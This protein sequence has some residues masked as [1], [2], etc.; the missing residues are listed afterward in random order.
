MQKV[1]QRPRVRIAQSPFSILNS[2]MALAKSKSLERSARWLI[3]RS[4]R[5]CNPTPNA[6][7]CTAWVTVRYISP[8]TKCF[9]RKWMIGMSTD[10]VYFGDFKL[11]IKTSPL[12]ELDTMI[13]NKSHENT[14]G[15]VPVCKGKDNRL[16]P[17]IRIEKR[18]WKFNA[19]LYHPARL[20]TREMLIEFQTTSGMTKRF[21]L[22]AKNR[23]IQH[24]TGLRTLYEYTKPRSGWL[25]SR[26]DEGRSKLR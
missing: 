7:G 4:E 14:Q 16:Y 3:R 17:I 1:R 9:G 21:R 26:T 2:P 10:T 22:D 8:F 20:K 24:R 13:K 19:H 15:Y 5:I 23:M 6:M 25:G 18:L 11:T 12:N